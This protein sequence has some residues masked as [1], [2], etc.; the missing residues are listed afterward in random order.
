MIEHLKMGSNS[1]DYQFAILPVQSQQ[2]MLS[3]VED[4]N[5]ILKQG[6]WLYFFLLILEGALRKWFF[7]GL[8]TPL[9]IVRDPLAIWLVIKAWRHG[10]LPSN[11]YLSGMMIVG[12]LGVYTAVIIGHGNLLVAIYG[13]RVLVLHFPLI[14]VIGSIFNREDVIRMGKVIVWISIPMTV[15]LALQFFSPQS[16]WVNRGLGGDVEGAGFGAGAHGFLRPPGTFSFIVGVVHYYSLVAC[17]ILYF[18]FRSKEINR[19]ILVTATICL[20]AAIPLSIS[21]GLFFGIGVSLLFFIIAIL[22]KPENISR[23][24][25]VCIGIVFALVVL[26]NTSLF[27]ISTEAFFSRFEN[28]TMSEGGLEGVIGERYLGGMLRALSQSSTLPFWGYGLGMGTNVGSM[29]LTG[30]TVFLIS[31]GE[32]GRVIGELGALMGIIVI[33]LRLGLC[34]KI[35]VA[36]YKRMLIGDMLPWI[37]LSFCLLIVPQG[38]WA[39]PTTLGFSTLIAGLTI[40]SL[41]VQKS[42]AIPKPL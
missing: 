15:L 41:R 21:R 8:A 23:I 35:A 9:L 10:L 31:E 5:R 7:P 3:A 22:R 29:L 42:K 4:T 37:L 32:W 34:T 25:P 17:F 11:I 2:M 30:E 13:A 20:I 6:I 26:S 36:C 18:W 1:K 38:Q 19:L 40:A 27:Q 16:A 12:I 24:I 28:A 14:F 33:L 39:R